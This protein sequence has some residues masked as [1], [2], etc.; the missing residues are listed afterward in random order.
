MVQNAA[1]EALSRRRIN[2]C[3][4]IESGSVICQLWT[5]DARSSENDKHAARNIMI[6][7]YASEITTIANSAVS[8]PFRESGLNVEINAAADHAATKRAA[9][10]QSGLSKRNSLRIKFTST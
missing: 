1:A 2:H 8:R 5:P 6:N 7:K 9:I 3:D 10:S 4:T